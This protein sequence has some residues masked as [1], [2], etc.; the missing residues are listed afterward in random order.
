MSDVLDL[1][2]YK[3]GEYL[4]LRDIGPSILDFGFIHC[5]ATYDVMPVYDGKAFCYDRH[6]GRFK[7]SAERYGLTIPDV[8][9]LEIIKELAKRN[10]ID[11]A[12][13]WFIIWRGFPPSGNP[14][15][16]ENCP[17][18]FAMYI[19]PSY[20]IAKNPQV[21]LYLDQDTNRVNDDYYGQQYKNMAWIEL[22]MS[23]RNKPEEYDTTV[24]VDTNGFVT[25]GPGFNV[26]IV[27]D[28]VIKT[29]NNNVLKGI[30][31]SVVKDIAKENN[32]TFKRMP[33]TTTMFHNADEI[34]ITSS[35]G[36]ITE[37]QKTGV[38]TKLLQEKYEN[39]KKEY[40]TEL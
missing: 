33:I 8:D 40:A 30:T 5:D 14:R 16:I 25:E 19:K 39:K 28:G 26:G 23:Q 2:A 15:D 20:P 36:G 13:V 7:A 24:L 11:N 1:I 34:F 31:M 9:P 3:N 10:P 38:V 21:K 4:P 27:K 37:T 22:T 18:N 12:F 35:S 6:L 17:V 29:A 32:I